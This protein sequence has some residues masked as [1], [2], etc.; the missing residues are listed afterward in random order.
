MVGLR[1]WWILGLVLLAV[2][3]GVTIF[4]VLT[5]GSKSRTQVLSAP[6]GRRLVFPRV[7]LTDNLDL[8]DPWGAKSMTILRVG[9][10]PP[11]PGGAGPSGPTIRAVVEFCATDGIMPPDPG[12]FELRFS[13]GAVVHGAALGIPGP[14]AAGACARGPITFP[15]PAGAVPISIAFPEPSMERTFIWTVR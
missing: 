7:R 10:E 5:I 15:V 8:P 14:L 2:G 3:A 1:I 9:N 4:A 13:G 6:V 11:T 12:N